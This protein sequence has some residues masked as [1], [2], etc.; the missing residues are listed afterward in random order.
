MIVFSFDTDHMTE[1]MM[2]LFVE[3]ILPPNLSCTFFCTQPFEV[4]RGRGHEIA[5]HPF[6][7]E[8]ESWVA[9]TA[10][11]RAK[12]EGVAGGPIRGVRPHSLVSS[13]TYIID[14]DARGVQYLSSITVS[15][16]TDVAAFRYPWGPV[17]I[18]IRYMDNMDLW[19]R[20]KRRLAHTPFSRDIIDFALDARLFCFDFHPVHLL[21]NTSA[22]SDYEAWVREG[23][24]E[25]LSPIERPD[26]GV[27]DFFLDVC[28]AIEKRGSP[29]A[30]CA[31]IA[32]SVP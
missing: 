19:A 32:T 27:R 23:R 30:T 16:A 29:L 12:L 18:P 24:P 4:L 28:A 11:L 6:L 17:E 21:L 7:K 20:D 14:L 10:Q 2:A 15:A 13:Q 9:E 3:R 25:L 22:F 8:R 1:R 5:A 31:E 26:C